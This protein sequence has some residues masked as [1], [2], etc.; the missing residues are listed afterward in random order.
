MTSPRKDPSEKAQSTRPARR[1][2]QRRDWAVVAVVAVIAIGLGAYLLARP[3]GSNT[4][5][6]NPVAAAPAA[7]DTTSTTNGR[8]SMGADPTGKG[9]N[10]STTIRSLSSGR[11]T[12][13]PSAMPSPRAGTTAAILP[14]LPSDGTK[15]TKIGPF[16][17]L[18][19]RIAGDPLAEGS[20]NAPVVMVMFSD[21][22]CPFCAEF[23]RTTEPV[24][25]KK[26]VDTGILRI[27]WRDFPIFGAQSTAAAIAGRAAAAQGRFFPFAQ[28][29]YA[30]APPTGHPDL[31]A[32]ALVGLARK[33]GVP[34][35]AAFKA[36]M[37]DPVAATAVAA[38]LNQVSNLGV[39][40]TPA[41]VINGYPLVGA[42]PLAEF[43]ALI[44]KIRALK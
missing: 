21:F 8:P 24:L 15:A 1:G 13:G 29:V 20:V 9:M 10:P 42:Q 40:S 35:I 19:H 3:S 43:T 14:T 44:D 34:D 12:A 22:R 39:P 7:P 37:D 17:D 33:A 36:A 41:F 32:A 31:S 2:V 16:G 18:A 6:T 28:A 27:E 30:V 5:S 4:A 23:S 38:D 25:V 11:S 26:Y